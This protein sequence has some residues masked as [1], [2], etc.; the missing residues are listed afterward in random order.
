MGSNHSTPFSSDNEG[1][2]ADT[3]NL[4][5]H[6]KEANHE[7]LNIKM[8]AAEI[9]PFSGE[10]SEWKRWKKKTVAAFGTVGLNRILEDKDYAEENTKSNNLVY[11]HLQVAVADGTASH[12]VDDCRLSRNK[13]WNA[14]WNKLLY[15]YEGDKLRRETGIEIRQKLTRLRLQPGT[16]AS[17]YIN[18]FRSLINDLNMIPN[19]RMPEVTSLTVS[20]FK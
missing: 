2:Y 1:T 6:I 8:K 9:Q 4:K 16:S 5:V 11:L 14:A 12:L 17:E 18:S 20:W 19:E 13:G 7:A 3:N 10:S 15:W